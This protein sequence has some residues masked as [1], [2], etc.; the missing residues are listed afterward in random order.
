[1]AVQ[2]PI[3][4]LAHLAEALG[5][6]A[7]TTVEEPAG[8]QNLSSHHWGGQ[9]GMLSFGAHLC[10]GQ[11]QVSSVLARTRPGADFLTK[12]VLETISGSSAARSPAA[13]IPK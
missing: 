6:L 11:A 1:M 12:R 3:A 13:S 4:A 7:G 2:F 10:Q 9:T 5:L 8:T